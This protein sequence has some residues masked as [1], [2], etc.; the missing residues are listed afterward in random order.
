VQAAG[1]LVAVLVELAAGVQHAHDDLG[2][3]ALGL[4]LVV[5]LDAD[6]DAAAVVGDRDRVVGVDG[7]DDVVAVAGQGLVDGVVHDLEDHVVQ[8]GA[9]GGVADVHAGALAHRFQPFEL[10]DA[11]FVVVFVRLGG[12]GG[13]VLR[14]GHGHLGD[15]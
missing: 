9:V 15:S 8:A 7:D 10:L 12:C 1:Y 5:H 4:V 14:F 6:R 11:G 3:A 2:G 13:L